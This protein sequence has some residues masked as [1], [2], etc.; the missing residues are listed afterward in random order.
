MHVAVIG[1]GAL[2]CVFAAHLAAHAEVWM[3]GAWAEGVAAVER[4]GIQLHQPKDGSRRA[5]VR[6]VSDPGEAPPADLALILVK[7]YQ[8][9]RAAAWA[10]QVLA[11]D[12]LAITFQNGLDNGA[13]LAAA[14]GSQRSAVGI[15]YLGATLMG[16]GEVRLAAL[17]PTYIGAPSRTCD[18]A[19]R[20]AALL[21]AA[22]LETHLVNDIE[23]RLWGKAVANAAINPLTALWRVT[24]GGLLATAERRALLSTLAQEAAAVA[25]A[26]GIV[27]PFDDA[28]AHV[29]GVCTAT[30]ANRSSMLQDIERGRPTEIDSINGIV[31]AEG[32]RLGLPTP[33]NEVV[34]RLVRGL[35]VEG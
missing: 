20:A 18:R 31:V 24:N 30:A 5:Q 10:S 22:G 4:N 14:V 17:G 32:R 25:A 8:T 6:A 23:G 12:G 2:G 7:S 21:A 13:K 9:E 3:L 27:L 34:W 28:G 33:A 26:R 19:A 29:A 16:P 15:T 1:T 35:Q 11:H